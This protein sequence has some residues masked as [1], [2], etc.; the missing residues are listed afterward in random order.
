M[1]KKSL[2][3]LIIA[4]GVIVIIG[5]FA[6]QGQPSKETGPSGE[7]TFPPITQNI[8]DGMIKEIDYQNTESFVMLVNTTNI[9]VATK[10][11]IEKNIRLDKWTEWALYDQYKDEEVSSKFTDAKEKDN[12]L[13][14]VKE[15]PESIN[16]IEEFTALKVMI[17]KR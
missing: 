7:E 10:N 17:F 12:I 16:D 1:S 9:A 8:L 4:V 5:L 15:D 6:W 3:I 11:P 13:V 14:F 2:S